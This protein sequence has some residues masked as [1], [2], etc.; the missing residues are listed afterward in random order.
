MK[1]TT[2][3]LGNKKK[4]KRKKKIEK[5]CLKMMI[6]ISF[7]RNTKKWNKFFISLTIFEL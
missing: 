6:K 7:K 2:E 3:N 1:K 5:E 4:K